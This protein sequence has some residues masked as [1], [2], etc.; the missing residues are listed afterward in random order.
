M[1][2]PLQ[3]KLLRALQ[4][5]EV[6]RVGTS[7]PM[8]INV[9]VIAACNEDSLGDGEGGRFREDLFYRLSVVRVKLPAL[10]ERIEDIPALAQ[11]FVE[12]SCRINDIELKELTQP[13]LQLLMRYNWPGNVRHCR[14]HRE[15]RGH[16]RRR[17]PDS[18][19][20]LPEENPG[21]VNRVVKANPTRL[22]PR[23]PLAGHAGRGHQLRLDDVS[24]RTGLILT[25]LQK[26]G[27]NKRQAARDAPAEPHDLDRQ[28]APAGRR[29][30][31]ALT[32]VEE[33]AEAVA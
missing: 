31:P 33:A 6:E 1:S 32:V 9:R 27:G 15:R 17:P 4:E 19:A 18:P 26:A 8:K 3:A 22:Q 14:T 10:R 16:E 12:E 25:Y 20:A 21:A 11:H 23:I 29:R 30:S 13:A 7:R 28:A 2:M 5:R 24:V